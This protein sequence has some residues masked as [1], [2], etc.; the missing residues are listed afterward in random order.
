MEPQNWKNTGPQTLH[1]DL[2]ILLFYTPKLR[3][4][5]PRMGLYAVWLAFKGRNTL[6][7]NG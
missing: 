6:M 2:T 1:T 7:M 4:S 5:N 3:N